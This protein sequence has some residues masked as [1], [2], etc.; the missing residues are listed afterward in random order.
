MSKKA[1]KIGTIVGVIIASLVGGFFIA[2]ILIPEG[3]IE[4]SPLWPY[5]C[6]GI[7]VLLTVLVV[8]GKL[9]TG[10][11]WRKYLSYFI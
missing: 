9:A 10:D 6:A 2:L 4:H 7:F 3:T 8:V 11:P 1:L 5:I